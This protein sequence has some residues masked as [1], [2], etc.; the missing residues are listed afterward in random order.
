MLTS[1][2]KAPQQFIDM[3]ISNFHISITT[4]I[5]QYLTWKRIF[6]SFLGAVL[7]CASVIGF[8][9]ED[10]SFKK[11]FPLPTDNVKL[12]K[13]TNNTEI[14]VK[15]LIKKTDSITAVTIT[16]LNF[17]RN[18][19]IITFIQIT[20]PAIQDIYNNYVNNQLYSVPI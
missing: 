14:R 17:Q 1:Q 9:L 5:I 2:V 3:S 13:V 19:R 12:L 6:F 18:A 10:F 4:K 7:A 8:E 11:K 16:T 20:N 15:E